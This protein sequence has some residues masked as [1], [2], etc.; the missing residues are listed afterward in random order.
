MSLK[1]TK[2]EL[3]RLGNPAQARV[4]QRFFKTGKG[5]YGEGDVFRGIKIPVLRKLAKNYQDM[6]C[7]EVGK[8]LTSKFHKTGCW[9][10]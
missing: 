3:Q 9:H 5:E 2:D 10:C 7:A 6:T 4:L 1:K 8:L